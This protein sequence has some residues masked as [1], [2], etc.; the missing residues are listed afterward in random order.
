M[1][2]YYQYDFESISLLSVYMWLNFIFSSYKNISVM[3]LVATHHI[4]CTTL[5]LHI[6]HGLHLPSFTAL[7]HSHPPLHQSHSCH[8]SLISPDC[9]TTPAPHSHTHL[10][11]T[12]PC[13]HCKVLF[14]PVWHFRAVSP[15]VFPCCYLDCSHDSDHLLPAYLTLPALWYPLCLPPA[16][17]IALPLLMILPCLCLPCSRYWTLPVWPPLVSTNKA[18]LGSIYTASSLQY[19]YKISLLDSYG[20]VL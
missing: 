8:Q 12:L 16:P 15:S 19:P 11:S 1:H 14:S 17:T 9:L 2:L 7:T 4:S 5:Q 20:S 13:K 18:A 6:T 10:S 3:N